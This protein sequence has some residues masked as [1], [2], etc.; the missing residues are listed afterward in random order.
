MTVKHSGAS[1]AFR[2][3]L[4][5]TVWETLK[6]G[7]HPNATYASHASRAT[8]AKCLRAMRTLSENFTQRTHRKQRNVRKH[9][10]L[11]AMCALRV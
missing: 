7:F 9:F 4:S 5:R 3:G 11:R 2:S 6:R 10:A 8:Q 1:K